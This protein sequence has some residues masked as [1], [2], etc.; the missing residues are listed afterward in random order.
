MTTTKIN[1]LDLVRRHDASH[2]TWEL[3][4][5]PYH[6]TK[7]VMCWVVTLH[8]AVRTPEHS[9]FAQYRVASHTI[10]LANGVELITDDY[11][12]HMVNQ[13]LEIAS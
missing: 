2:A 9:W 10:Q 5:D 6:V 3:I 7:G 8:N 1:L 13:R 11:I 12:A 4:E